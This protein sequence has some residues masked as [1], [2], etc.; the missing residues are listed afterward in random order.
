VGLTPAVASRDPDVVSFGGDSLFLVGEVTLS[1][2]YDQGP[3]LAHGAALNSSD[4]EI[5]SL[6]LDPRY[7]KRREEVPLAAPHDGVAADA[8]TESSGDQRGSREQNHDP[9]E[10]PRSG[11]LRHVASIARIRRPDSP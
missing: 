8:V 7:P 5:E 4:T 9:E 6:E 10:D 11:S 2:R 3:V 1:Y